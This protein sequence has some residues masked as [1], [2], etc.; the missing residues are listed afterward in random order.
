M[1][2]GP[3]M[4]GTTGMKLEYSAWMPRIAIWTTVLVI[5]VRVAAYRGFA[6]YVV[7]VLLAI[8]FP[9]ALFAGLVCSPRR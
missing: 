9:V 6:P 7:L 8:L 2:P 4:L 5:G 3:E 1:Q